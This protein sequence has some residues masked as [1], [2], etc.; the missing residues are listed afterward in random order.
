MLTDYIIQGHVISLV[1]GLVDEKDGW[2]WSQV[3]GRACIWD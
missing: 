3:R 1:M 2:G